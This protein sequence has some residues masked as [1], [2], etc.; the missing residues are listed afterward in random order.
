MGWAERNHRRRKLER[1][2]KKKGIR[3]TFKL[4]VQ[5]EKFLIQGEYS[6][7]PDN[8]LEGTDGRSYFIYLL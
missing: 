2:G 5:H 6:F 4:I 1:K 7:T 8:L 3:V